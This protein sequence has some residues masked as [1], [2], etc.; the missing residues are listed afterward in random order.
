MVHLAVVSEEPKT[1]LRTPPSY[2]DVD[3]LPL[4]LHR[5]LEKINLRRKRL[6]EELERLDREAA[7]IESQRRRG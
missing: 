3:G 2:V 6:L 4:D 5:E 7:H 1:D